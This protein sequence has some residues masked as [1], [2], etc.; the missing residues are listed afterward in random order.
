[1]VNAFRGRF[2]MISD[3]MNIVDLANTKPRKGESMVDYSN[4]WRNFSIKCDGTLT[5]NEAVNLIKK[6]YRWMDGDALKCDQS[7]HAQRFTKSIV[8]H[9]KHV[10]C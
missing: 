9:E 4:R 2:T 6:K 10:L 5:E 7:Q 1:M 3:K 8:Q